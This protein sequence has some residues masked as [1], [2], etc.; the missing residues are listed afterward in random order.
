MRRTL[1]TQTAIFFVL[2]QFRTG[3]VRRAT[4]SAVH[5]RHLASQIILLLLHLSSKPKFSADLYIFDSVSKCT[6]KQQSLGGPSIS[7]TISNKIINQEI[8]GRKRNSESGERNGGT[9]WAG[10]AST[11]L[12]IQTR[13][14]LGQG[15]S[16]YPFLFTVVR[17]S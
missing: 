11:F 5:R 2:Y 4:I 6:L 12:T 7:A 14:D 3:H 8:L 16:T 1:A 10:E 17:R 15:V 9:E 13:H